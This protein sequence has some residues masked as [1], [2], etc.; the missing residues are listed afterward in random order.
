MENLSFQTFQVVQV[1]LI[2]IEE[3]VQLEKSARIILAINNE[4]NGRTNKQRTFLKSMG[5]I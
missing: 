3:S 5:S 2:M 1:I 4:V